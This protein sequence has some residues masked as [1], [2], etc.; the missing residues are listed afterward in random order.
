MGS[1]RQETKVVTVEGK[2]DSKKAAFAAALGSVQKQ[3]LKGN[4]DVLLRIEP[5]DVEITKAKEIIETERFMF[6]F[7]P[8]EKKTYEVTLKVTVNIAD[9]S[10]EQV[11]FATETK[12]SYNPLKIL[13]KQS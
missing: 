3:V 7:F 13:S 1:I 4:D 9:V 6:L 8:R 5:V 12:G 11:V 2:G 10:L